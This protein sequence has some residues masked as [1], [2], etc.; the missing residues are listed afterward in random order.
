MQ[1]NTNALNELLELANELPDASSGGGEC[2]ATQDFLV[3]DNSIY[4]IGLDG[5]LT[6][7][8]IEDMTDTDNATFMEY[9]RTNIFQMGG[10]NNSNYPD[11]TNPGRQGAR[12]RFLFSDFTN[13]KFPNLYLCLKYAAEANKIDSMI[14]E[15]IGGPGT[16]AAEC[17]MIADIYTVGATH[18]Q[19]QICCK[20]GTYNTDGWKKLGTPVDLTSEQIISGTKI[21]N[22]TIAIGGQLWDRTAFQGDAGQILSSTGIG[23]EWV[24]PPT[25]GSSTELALHSTWTGTKNIDRYT[26]SADIEY[27]TYLVKVTLSLSD[28]DSI[29]TSAYAILWA[30]PMGSFNATK[31]TFYGEPGIEALSEANI[32]IGFTSNIGGPT[33]GIIINGDFGINNITDSDVS[34]SS[35]AVFNLSS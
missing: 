24:D 9:C 21:F 12:G 6:L 14:V 2:N 1:N 8:N 5:T 34:V 17:T 25:G 15:C 10:V 22:D 19:L 35:I 33:N 20:E 29:Y 30:G 31:L 4:S 11:S 26:L 18:Y 28:T 13:V 3:T 23:V 7:L 27:G 32:Y 16:S